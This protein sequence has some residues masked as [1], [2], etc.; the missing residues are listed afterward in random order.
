MKNKP[1]DLLV[2]TGSGNSILNAG[3]RPAQE[4]DNH[5]IDNHD[6]S[7]YIVNLCAWSTNNPEIMFILLL[8]SVILCWGYPTVLQP[9]IFYNYI[10]FIAKHWGTK[11]T[12]SP[13]QTLGGHLLPVPLKLAIGHWLLWRNNVQMLSLLAY[14]TVQPGLMQVVGF[15]KIFNWKTLRIKRI[16]WDICLLVFWL[17]SMFLETKKVRDNFPS[18]TKILLP[19]IVL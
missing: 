11:Y 4:S 2:N 13:S 19:K 12:V 5:D 17:Y 3:Y 6:K 7:V 18:K 10:T 14:S 16:V 9:C 1:Q 15:T 8:Y